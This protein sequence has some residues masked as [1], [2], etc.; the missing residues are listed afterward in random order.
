MLETTY[1]YF[2]ISK[3]KIHTK[4]T[5]TP[6]SG[7]LPCPSKSERSIS[8]AKNT[9]RGSCQSTDLACLFQKPSIPKRP[10]NTEIKI[11]FVKTHQI[12]YSSSFCIFIIFKLYL[13]KKMK[14]MEKEKVHYQ[15]LWL[16][17]TKFISIVPNRVKSRK[18]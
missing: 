5:Q 16:N 17:E 12:V 8:Y 6:K 15:I 4:K 7:L 14:E 10:D 3:A 2:I 9:R 1:L 11:V 18:Q 13:N